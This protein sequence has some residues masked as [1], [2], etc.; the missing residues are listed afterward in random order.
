MVGGYYLCH[1]GL[2]IDQLIDANHLEVDPVEGE[3][4]SCAPGKAYSLALDIAT[5]LPLAISLAFK[6][7]RSIL[8]S[9][10]AFWDDFQRT[11]ATWVEA[12]YW[13]REVK[14]YRDVAFEDA[15]RMESGKCAPVYISPAAV[16]R[17]AKREEL[18][19][20]V[21]SAIMTTNMAMN[22]ID[23]SS[24]WL[25]DLKEGR[26][27]SFVALAV[28]HRFL[29]T[30]IPTFEEMLYAILHTSLL[31]AYL[32]HVCTLIAQTEQTIAPIGATLWRPLLTDLRYQAMQRRDAFRTG[33][34][35]I[36]SSLFAEE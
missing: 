11:C 28:S 14:S 34:V 36:S 26:F 8:D 2:A 27:N 5:T 7:F 10:S 23:D 33:L 3:D 35:S 18:I 30:A 19:A 25:I 1:Y 12:M 13:E 6:Q 4:A 31:D 17:A 22:L 24:D 20:D 16:C 15:M 32:D 21:E 29:D 9:D